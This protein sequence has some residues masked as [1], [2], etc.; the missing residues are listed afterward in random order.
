MALAFVHYRFCGGRGR[1]HRLWF[2]LIAA[3]TSCAVPAAA[4]PAGGGNLA[5]EQ[6]LLHGE[7]SSLDGSWERLYRSGLDS[8]GQRLYADAERRLAA[9]ARLA[10]GWPVDDRRL[11]KSNIALAEV[12]YAE[13]KYDRAERLFSS[14]LAQVKR[15]PVAGPLAEAQ[16]LEGLARTDLCRGRAPQAE[17]LA[18]QALKIQE[19]KA[20]GDED[21][22]GR[23]LHTLAVALSRQGWGQEAEPI[24]GRSLSI[25][26]KHPGPDSLDLA[27]GLRDLALFYQ[28]RGRA[29]ES[30]RMFERSLAIKERAVRLDLPPAVA[31]V[32][33]F[34]WD[35]GSPGA[36]Q[37]VD[38]QYPLKFMTVGGLRVAA[39]VVDS[40]QLLDV[41]VSLKNDS[42]KRIEIGVGPVAM[43][44]VRPRV[45]HLERLAPEQIDS[46]LEELTVW[47]WTHR[48]PSLAYLQQNTINT[49]QATG[50]APF[51]DT[52]SG[53]VFG[54]YGRWTQSS[55][56]FS[57]AAARTRIQ[58]ELDRLIDSGHLKFNVVRALDVTG[59][60]LEPG[61]SRTGLVFF[62]NPHVGDAVLRVFVGNVSFDFPFKLSG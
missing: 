16:C 42:P 2:A 30:Q 24:F 31:G 55:A 10:R 20:P 59:V 39:T 37:I 4:Q 35:D 13:G 18:R 15:T 47:D 21:C 48:Q 62:S 14:T 33:N 36:G 5:Y 57:D 53:N 27:E 8:Y 49:A 41:L 40:M 9:A 23:A 45:K 38:G 52:T 54:Q 17:S 58:T 26:E 6:P 61:E 46:V 50:R 11:A 25:L 51:A 7:V 22:L 12:Y 32:I 60:S 34:P 56:K 43:Q 28:A 1:V 3:A 29:A 44:L 19:G